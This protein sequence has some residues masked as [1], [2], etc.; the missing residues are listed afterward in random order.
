MNSLHSFHRRQ[1]GFTL[2][3][4]I[5][6]LSVFAMA[7]VG[8]ITAMNTAMQA[9]LEVRQ[10]AQIRQELESRIALRQAIP[11][12]TEKLVI[13]A[14]D[15]HGIRVEETLVP[16]SLQNKD[17]EELP[18]IKKLTITATLGQQSDMASILVNQP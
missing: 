10:R 1:R 16:Q 9:A 4:V 2:L 3:E 7:V 5:I 6:A 12:D 15:N 17:G 11:L 14:K 13:D 18:N 8:L